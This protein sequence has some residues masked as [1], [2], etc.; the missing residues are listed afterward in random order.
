MFKRLNKVGAVEHL[1][2]ALWWAVLGVNVVISQLPNVKD[3]FRAKKA[4]TLCE[5]GYKGV[6]CSDVATMNKA[7]I[8]A[9]IK[10]DLT[11][12]QPVMRERLGG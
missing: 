2:I 11:T 3:N 7:E 12:P 6:S 8:L 1:V 10:D 9:Y 5:Q 4:Q